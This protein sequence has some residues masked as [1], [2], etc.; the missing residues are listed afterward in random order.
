MHTFF[1]LTGG[2]LI[3]ALSLSAAFSQTSNGRV[4]AKTDWA[5]FV[6]NEPSKMCWVVSAPTKIENS[7]KGVSRGEIQLM[8]TYRPGSANAEIAFTGGYPFKPDS[9]VKLQIGTAVYD[10]YVDGDWAW[11]ATA[12]DD[13][14]VRESM[15]A[16]AEALVTGESARGTVTKDTFSLLGFTAALQAAEKN[17]T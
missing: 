1:R 9:T 8:V 15:K 4:D 11:P 2:A 17:C 7:K 16:G 14:Q 10:L 5:V 3:A 12:N 13:A 6:E